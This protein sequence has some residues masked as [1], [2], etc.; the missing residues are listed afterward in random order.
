MGANVWAVREN[1]AFPHRPQVHEP[2]AN[3][4]LPE[5]AVLP[6]IVVLRRRG[7]SLD[8]WGKCRR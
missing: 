2:T 5:I 4:T 8:S 3:E 1:L 6:S 7:G